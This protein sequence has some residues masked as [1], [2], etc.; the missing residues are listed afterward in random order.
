MYNDYTKWEISIYIIIWQGDRETEPMGV[1]IFIKE[2]ERY[3]ARFSDIPYNS[4]CCWLPYSQTLDTKIT[5]ILSSRG[6][7]LQGDWQELMGQF[8]RFVASVRDS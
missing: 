2:W 5:I 4:T 8:A 7:G 1:I 3:N 6:I